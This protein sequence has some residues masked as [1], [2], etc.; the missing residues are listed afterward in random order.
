[1]TGNGEQTGPQGIPPLIITVRSD[2]K[3]VDVQGPLQDKILC[4]R[5]LTDAAVEILNF[6]ASK[7]I[8]PG[9]VAPSGPLGVQ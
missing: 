2:G 8:V 3:G 6:Q 9:M 5:M 4:W 7:I 1:M